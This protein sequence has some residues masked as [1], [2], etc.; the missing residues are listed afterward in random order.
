MLHQQPAATRAS[1]SITFELHLCH[2]YFQDT[3]RD[4]NNLFLFIYLFFPP[5]QLDIY[6]HIIFPQSNDLRLQHG[7]WTPC[8][9]SFQCA[10]SKLSSLV[11]K[12]TIQRAENDRKCFWKTIRGHFSEIQ[13][14]LHLKI[15][16]WSQV[17]AGVGEKYKRRKSRTLGVSAWHSCC[18][19]VSLKTIYCLCSWFLQWFLRRNYSRSN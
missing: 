14:Y 15:Q 17:M 10:V 7:V 6:Y 3:G 12:A 4:K 1:C 9:Y 13:A 2:F 5:N 11:I 18:K 16:K 19:E 8:L